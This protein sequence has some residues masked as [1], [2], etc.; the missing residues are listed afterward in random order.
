MT[1]SA[2]GDNMLWWGGKV[3]WVLVRGGFVWLLA[4][5]VDEVRASCVV[6]SAVGSID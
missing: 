4:A 5:P 6:V 3:E 2:L 1:R